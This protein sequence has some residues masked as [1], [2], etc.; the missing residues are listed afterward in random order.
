MKRWTGGT[1]RLGLATPSVLLLV[2]LLGG[3]GL[4]LTGPKHRIEKMFVPAVVRQMPRAALLAA[5]E[6]LQVD[7]RSI[8]VMP[9]LWWDLGPTLGPGR[10]P[11]MIAVIR[12]RAGAEPVFPAGVVAKYLWVLRDEQ[13]W[14]SV[15]FLEQPNHYPPNEVDRVAR[16]GPDYDGIMTATVIVGVLDPDGTLHL[17]RVSGV[18]IDT[19][20]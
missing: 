18:T 2:S 15:L 3:C 19:P 16:D 17:V 9:Y 13:R 12:L 5:P 11:G 20:I 4:D 10:R 7:G 14:Q 1:W 8:D 6:S